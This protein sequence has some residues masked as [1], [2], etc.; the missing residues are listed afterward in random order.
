MIQHIPLC[1]APGAGKSE[2]AK[3]LARDWGFVSIDDSWILREA[4]QI[5]YGLTDWHVSTQEGKASAIKVGEDW[6]EVR[7]LLGELGLHLEQRD[8][9]HIPKRALE[10]ALAANPGK[11]LCF[12]SVRRDQ[13]RV[14]KDTGRALVV[15]IVRP[16]FVPINGF[17]H[18]DRSLVDVTITNHYD[19]QDPEGSSQRLT[20]QIN[21]LVAPY[22]R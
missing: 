15:E 2:T 5:L 13:A 3:I 11:R 10:E 18:Y 17:D 9:H 7:K 12:G 22:L 20:D 16:G 6:I 8:P 1:G 14:Y 4:A 19:P 21:L